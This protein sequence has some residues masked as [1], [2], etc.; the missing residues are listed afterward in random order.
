MRARRQR[1][2]ARGR[3][4]GRL[5]RGKFGVVAPADGSGSPHLGA[6][7]V[8]LMKLRSGGMQLA[9]RIPALPLLV[10][11]RIEEA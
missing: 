1:W 8:N 7:R 5:E 3:R 4:V 11:G 9:V 2:A 10:D 6:R